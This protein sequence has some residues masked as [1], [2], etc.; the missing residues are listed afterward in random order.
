ME[1]FSFNFFG[2][3]GSEA[4]RDP[5][6]YTSPVEEGVTAEEVPQ[7]QGVQVQH[8]CTDS[9]NEK[10]NPATFSSKPVTRCRCCK[11]LLWCSWTVV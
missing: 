9:S 5:V 6:A 11:S 3:V 8:L 1:S 4:N 10:R 2:A 7:A